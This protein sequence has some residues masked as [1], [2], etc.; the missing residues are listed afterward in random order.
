VLFFIDLFFF[1]VQADAAKPWQL[2]FQFPATPTIEGIIHFHNDIIGL[3][4]LIVVFVG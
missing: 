2:G 3:I 4:V 1:T